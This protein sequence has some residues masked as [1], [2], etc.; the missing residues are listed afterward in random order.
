MRINV[1]VIAIIAAA[2]GTLSGIG[3]IDISLGP[4]TF[5]HSIP[6][7]LVGHIDGKR[8]GQGILRVEHKDRPGTALDAGADF[9]K[10]ILYAAVAVDLVAEEIGHND[11]PGTDIGD[12]LLQSRLITFQHSVFMHGFSLP[13]RTADQVGRNPVQKIGAGFIQQAVMSRGCERVLD[14]VAGGGLAVC[15]G[16]DNDLHPL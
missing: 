2:P 16:D 11:C 15:T 10:R 5:V 4:H 14:H 3:K 9:L 12:D 1:V 7:D 8:S 6:D 13:V